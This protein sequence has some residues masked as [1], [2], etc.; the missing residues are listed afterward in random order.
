MN[1]PIVVSSWTSEKSC[2][3]VLS[4][5]DAKATE[6]YTMEGS[7]VRQLTHQNDALIGELQLGATDEVAFRSADGT[8]VHGLLTK[9]AG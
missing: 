5:G 9:P 1:P 3:A 8:E 6:V 4:G 2:S 7:S